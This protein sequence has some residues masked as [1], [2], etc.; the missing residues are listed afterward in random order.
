[1]AADVESLGMAVRVTRTVMLSREDRENLA[2]ITL[3]FAA[4]LREDV[5]PRGRA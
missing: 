3:D 1:M 4:A 2:R 5:G